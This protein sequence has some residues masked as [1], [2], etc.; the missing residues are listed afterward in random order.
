MTAIRHGGLSGH[1][2]EFDKAATK[3]INRMLGFISSSR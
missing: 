2:R 3:K 1:T